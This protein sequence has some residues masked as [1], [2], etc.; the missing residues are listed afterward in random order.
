M[1]DY[2]CYPLWEASPGAVGNIDPAT[3]P[4]SRGLVAQLAEWAGLYDATL[5]IDDPVQSGFRSDEERLAFIDAG[6]RLAE[7]LQTELG[8]DYLVKV[9]I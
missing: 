6:N 2:Q 4:I 3:L 7:A 8:S 9:R 1:P 5:N